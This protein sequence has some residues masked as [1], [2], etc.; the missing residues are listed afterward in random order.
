[1][2]EV[3]VVSVLTGFGVPVAAASAGVLAWRLVNFW[4]PIPFG[5]ASYLSLR[6]HRPPAADPEIS[7]ASAN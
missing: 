5:G 7:Q 1:V 3:T 2:I 4:L 6:L